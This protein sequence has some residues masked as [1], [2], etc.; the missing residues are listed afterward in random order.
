[1]GLDPEQKPGPRAP[2]TRAERH[3]DN[4]RRS[5]RTRQAQAEPA[6]K[7]RPPACTKRLVLIRGRRL[8]RGQLGSGWVGG[9]ACQEDVLLRWRP[10]GGDVVTSVQPVERGWA[11]RLTGRGITSIPTL[12]HDADPSQES[13][14]YCMLMLYGFNRSARCGPEIPIL[15]RPPPP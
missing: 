1:Q 3:R 2:A 11:A 4:P 10:A 14:R 12:R 6:V 15:S 5:K 8:G 7:D 13:P 9:P